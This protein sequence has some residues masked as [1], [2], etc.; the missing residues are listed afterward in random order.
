MHEIIRQLA[1]GDD[2]K[3]LRL[4]M[5][6]GAGGSWY[7]SIDKLH[8]GQVIWQGGKWTAHVNE[9]HEVADIAMI[10]SMVTDVMPEGPFG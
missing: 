5:A 9:S 8:Y 1:Y 7:V 3:Q 2:V 10:E 6:P 4:Y